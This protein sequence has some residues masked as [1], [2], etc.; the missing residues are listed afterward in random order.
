MRFDKKLLLFEL[1]R[2]CVLLLL[3]GPYREQQKR[4]ISID[5]ML[6]EHDYVFQKK[7]AAPRDG[8]T[9]LFE[10][11]HRWRGHIGEH[12]ASVSSQETLLLG[13]VLLRKEL[14]ERLV[15][16]CD[17]NP[18]RSVVPGSTFL[19]Q[20][21]GTR[22]VF[23]LTL[24]QRQVGHGKN[25]RVR[26]EL[27]FSNDSHFDKDTFL[28]L[29]EGGICFLDHGVLVRLY[30]DGVIDGREYKVL[31]KLFPAEERRLLPTRSLRSRLGFESEGSDFVKKEDAGLERTA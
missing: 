31:N 18:E 30:D 25:S 2:R 20:G 28:G 19:G 13:G 24:S 22:S 4:F 26:S 6:E 15:W 3:P 14:L 16:L 17:V 29:I 1:M 7:G 21:I 10:S 23:T 5:G 27:S 8:D 11:A 9:R 12:E